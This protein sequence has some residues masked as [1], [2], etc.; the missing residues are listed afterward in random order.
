MSGCSYTAEGSHEE[1]R[2]QL[3]LWINTFCP[4]TSLNVFSSMASTMISRS[5]MS[6]PQN[7]M[8]EV[9]TSRILGR[10]GEGQ[11]QDGGKRSMATNEDNAN[12]C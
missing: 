10:G 8:L 5:L 11:G 1:E 2:R 9:I 6:K 12:I 7:R 3:L 4:P